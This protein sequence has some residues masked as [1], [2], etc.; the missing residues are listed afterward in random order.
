VATITG[1]IL[2]SL[3]KIWPWKDTLEWGLDRHGVQV[4]LVQQNVLPAGVT[5]ELGIALALMAT[6]FVVV[7]LLERQAGQQTA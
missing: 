5:P 6:G 3:R 1:L 2:G 4:P 7:L